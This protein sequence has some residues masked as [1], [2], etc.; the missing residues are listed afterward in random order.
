MFFVLVTQ[1]NKSCFISRYVCKFLI[2]HE[3]PVALTLKPLEQ[4]EQNHWSLCNDTS[5][6][7]HTHAGSIKSIKSESVFTH[8]AADDRG[9]LG[10]E[11]VLTIALV[12]Y[13]WWR[14][15]IK[16]RKCRQSNPTLHVTSALWLRAEVHQ[17]WDFINTSVIP[18]CTEI[19]HR[20]Y[21]FIIHQIWP[22][23]WVLNDGIQ[24]S[25]VARTILHTW[26][27]GCCNEGG[28]C[29]FICAFI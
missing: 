19:W 24:S 25:L 6:N 5:N 16:M 7:D 22:C 14:E 15:D 2:S 26:K 18:K 20:H 9:L 11:N 13:T 28:R 29:A 4:V 23:H 8:D 27:W 3:I 21:P 10:N 1:K 17:R 12:Q